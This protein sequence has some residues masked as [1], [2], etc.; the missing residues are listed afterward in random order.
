MSF[1]R[2]DGITTAAT[3]ALALIVLVVLPGQPEESR[4]FAGF[5]AM[6]QM[7]L[8]HE[9]NGVEV[10]WLDAVSGNTAII[11]TATT[12]QNADGRWCRRYSMS[13]KAGPDARE[14]DASSHVACRT[15]D[16]GWQAEDGARDSPQEARRPD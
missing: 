3:A 6:R 5:E 4:G 2:L 8:E 11:T 16:G 7:T 14:N 9:A 13:T 15:A 12:F 10:V 1:K